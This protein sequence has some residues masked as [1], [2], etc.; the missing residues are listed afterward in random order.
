MI[1]E[2]LALAAAA[3][4][5]AAEQLDALDPARCDPGAWLGVASGLAE[6]G[7]KDEALAAV[8][9]AGRCGA[10]APVLARARALVLAST[11][12]TSEAVD[13]LD[14]ALRLEPG[15]AEL[16]SAR[17][18]ALR[19]LGNTEAAAADL[20]Q[21]VAGAGRLTP[22][23]AVM[24]VDLDLALGQPEQALADADAAIAR[25][26]P[27]PIL[28]E[29]ALTLELALGRPVAALARLDGLPETASWLDRRGTVLAWSGDPD[30]AV[31]AWDRARTVA[32]SRPTAANRALV[33]ALDAALEAW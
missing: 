21:V 12:T 33:R 25:I 4:P 19:E 29:R 17:A 24:L 23:A 30:A 18:S 8:G 10:E 9:A 6:E 16:L 26:G 31:R 20:R 22:D 28:V 11:G 2:W 3:H 15:S 13:A 1:H 27:A 32:L 7:R 14:E 5:S